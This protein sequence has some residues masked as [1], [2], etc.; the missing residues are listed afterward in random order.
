MTEQSL[1]SGSPDL[2][3]ELC[4][5]ND[6]E[7]GGAQRFDVGDRELAVVRLGES[8]YI[9][10]DRCSHGN[11][12]LSGGEVDEDDLTLECP[13]HGSLFNLE[14]GDA[15]TLP[16]IKPVPSYVTKVVDG[17]VYVEIEETNG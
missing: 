6:L 17:I 15:L 10:G 4:A 1:A 12:S 16:A 13:K 14:T 8:V 5:L 7:D 3:V 2:N 11:V 9:I